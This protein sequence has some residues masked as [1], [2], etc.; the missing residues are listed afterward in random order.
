MKV[1]IQEQQILASGE[2]KGARRIP[3]QFLLRG[4]HSL[5]VR[6][7]RLFIG[8]QIVSISGTW[9]QTTAQAWLVL[10]LSNSP[11]ALGLVTTLQFLPVM[12]LALFGG[13]LADRLPKRRTLIATQTL[14]LI[15]ATIFG[16]L[17]ATNSI[18]LWHIY[19]LAVIQGCVQAIDTPTRQAFVAEM[20]GHDELTNAIALNS[21]TFNGG[22]II[23]PAL[24]GFVIARIGVAPALFFNALSYVAVVIA[25]LLMNE[26]AL[27][28]A[29]VV[30]QGSAWHRLKEGLSYTRRTPQVLAIIIVLAAI[31]TFG[32][33][34]TV[35]LPLIASYVL[36]TDA[37]GFGALSSFLGV[38]SLV[39]ALSTAYVRE[40]T[41]RRLLLGAAAF[42]L[43][44]ALTAIT[45]VFAISAP[46]LTALGAAAIVFSTSANTLLQLTVPNELRGRVMSLQVLLVMGS[47]PIGAFVI[48]LLSEHVGVPAALLTCAFLCT[49]GVAGGLRY[50]R[51]HRIPSA[52][53]H[54]EA[55]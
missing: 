28:A 33:N 49:L 37:Q 9:M 10:Q 32:Y 44:F 50:R 41:M 8:G 14:L 11:F 39:A 21:M 35:V 12:L 42:S 3:T 31:G 4:F 40:V 45:P 24:A 7:F 47:T 16:L 52:E 36:H 55:D 2:V 18:Q 43:L 51:T 13:V 38:G 5:T 29:V 6:N 30:P 15:Q 46:L 27:F 22:R 1:E 34:F 19:L 53:V 54:P 20:V 26:K 48:G 17:V 23:G 25:L